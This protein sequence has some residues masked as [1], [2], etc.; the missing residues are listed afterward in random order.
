M[1][2]ILKARQLAALKHEGQKYGEHPYTYHLLE[3]ENVAIRMY[4]LGTVCIEE[5]QT[6]CLLHDILED[7][8]TSVSELKLLGF[9][10]AVITAVSLC[11]KDNETS[12]KDYI[13]AIRGNELARKVKLCD[14]AANLMNSIIACN[15]KRIN[16]YTKQI[17]LLGGF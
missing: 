16:K 6:A 10:D 17:Q 7:T 1:N 14:T 2:P 8:D 11:T 15:A 4:G 5:L 13:W 9:T 3:V 12:Y